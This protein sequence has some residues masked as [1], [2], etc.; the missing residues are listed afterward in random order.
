MRTSNM[1]EFEFSHLDNLDI[2]IYCIPC[3]FPNSKLYICFESFWKSYSW[4]WIEC[5]ITSLNSNW[6]KKKFRSTRVSWTWA[7]CRKS[8]SSIREKYFWVLTEECWALSR[9]LETRGLPST[10]PVFLQIQQN[11]DSKPA[12]ICLDSA[13]WAGQCLKFILACSRLTKLHF[14]NHPNF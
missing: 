12:S 8:E 3:K 11:K 1:L 14:Q 9:R 6:R 10:W 5:P 4:P 13:Q 2:L 7:T